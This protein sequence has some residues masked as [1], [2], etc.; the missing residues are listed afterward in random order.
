MILMQWPF[1]GCQ[2][3]GKNVHTL[4]LSATHRRSVCL[5]GSAMGALGTSF[6]LGATLGGPSSSESRAAK[7]FDCGWGRD[8][9]ETNGQ[10][11]G[12]RTDELAIEMGTGNGMGNPIQ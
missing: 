5:D 11:E 7:K 1:S 12:R 8:G 4:D 10:A 2:S 6:F 9:E 3:D